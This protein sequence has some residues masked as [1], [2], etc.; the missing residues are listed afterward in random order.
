MLSWPEALARLPG[1]PTGRYGSSADGGRA[2]R[3]TF[4]PRASDK[5][6]SWAPA[7]LIAFETDRSGDWDIWVMESDGGNP[8]P[9]IANDGV[10]DFFPAWAPSP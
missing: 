1:C 2:E 8:D 4:S 9:L 10:D 7:E 3:L 5:A 6:P